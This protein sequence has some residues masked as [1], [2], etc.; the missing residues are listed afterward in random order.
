M[1]VSEGLTEDGIFVGNTYDK[2]NS[3]N[4]IVQRLM[5]GFDDALGMLV[6]RVR[7]REIHEV[8]CGEGYWTLRWHKAGIAARGSDFSSV[9]IELARENARDRQIDADIFS[10]GNVYDLQPERDRAE[11][12]VCCEVLEHLDDPDAGLHALQ[13]IADPWLIVSVPREPLWSAM[14]VARGKYWGKLGN[15][16]GHVQRWSAAAFVRRVSQYFDVVA[17]RT[18]IPW[19]MLLC[20]Q[21]GA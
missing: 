7:P 17:M 4:V 2:Y 20:R 18:P 13:R 1:R 5:R 11:L 9:A 14:N 10:V 6:A 16:P 3:R 15:T 19:T 8:G 21:R 12:V